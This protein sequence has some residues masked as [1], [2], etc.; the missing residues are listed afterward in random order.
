MLGQDK[1]PVE[2]GYMRQLDHTCSIPALKMGGGSEFIYQKPD[3][4]SVV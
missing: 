1:L 4:K 2:E 3:R